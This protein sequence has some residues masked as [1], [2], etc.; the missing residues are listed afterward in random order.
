MDKGE[1]GD[2]LCNLLLIM[3]EIFN[4]ELAKVKISKTTGIDNVPANLIKAIG[5]H[6]LSTCMN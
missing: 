6:T 3:Q 4:L 5:D 2:F 1:K